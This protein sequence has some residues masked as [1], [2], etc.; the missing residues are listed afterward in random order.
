MPP[1]IRTVR[2]EFY[3]H[4]RLQDLG[5]I[6]MLVFAGLFCQADREGRFLWRPR[7]L[8][9]DIL[10]F[11]EFDI[12]SVLEQLA[13]HDFIKRYEV[14]GE[15]YGYIP[16]WA[17]HQVI[18]NREAASALPD[19]HASSTSDSRVNHASGDASSTRHGLA[20]VEGKGRE[21]EG[22]R[23]DASLTH[24]ENRSLLPEV[25]AKEVMVQ[26]RISGKYIME[27]LTDVIRAEMLQG[28]T[29]D[30]LL[31]QMVAARKDHDANVG[32]LKKALRAEEFFGQRHWCDRGL[33]PWKEGQE[34]KPLP[35]SR[36]YEP[37]EVSA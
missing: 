9:L 19:P 14:D 13:A 37:A 31:A 11:L 12:S 20:P 30:D 26:L 23:K 27:A 5:P 29:P 32:K 24:G 17:K 35:P 15:P 4:E 33:W 16:S 36:R 22:K 6:P 3:R 8:K 2:P 25:V 10:P 28:K 21:E 7:H 18:N 1:R 34:P